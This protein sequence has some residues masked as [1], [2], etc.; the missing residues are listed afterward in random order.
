M[1][2][3]RPA[4]FHKCESTSKVAL[5]ALWLAGQSPEG[6]NAQESCLLSSRVI[7]PQLSLGRW[8][9][10]A[11]DGELRHRT[12]GPAAGS[13]QFGY[14][15]LGYLRA[16]ERIA[17]HHKKMLRT[18]RYVGFRVLRLGGRKREL[19]TRRPAVLPDGPNQRG[20]FDF[21]SG[22]LTCGQRFRIQF[23]VDAFL[24]KCLAQLADT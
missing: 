19:G 23:V 4:D 15:R 24:R 8:H 13:S 5:A 9:A 3:A 18:Y 16:R 2:P 21:V 22:S 20:R 7:C 17:P 12:R 11:D 6:P 1:S 14:H 10:T